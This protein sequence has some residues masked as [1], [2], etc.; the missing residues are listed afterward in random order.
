MPDLTISALVAGQTT[1]DEAGVSPVSAVGVTSTVTSPYTTEKVALSFT[2]HRAL[3][4]LEIGVLSTWSATYTVRVSSADVQAA[5]HGLVFTPTVHW[6]C[7]PPTG[8]HA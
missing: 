4:H 7:P 1:T 2:V 5:P 3:S 8:G 6:A